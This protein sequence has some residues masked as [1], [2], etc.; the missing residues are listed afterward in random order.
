MTE[1][2]QYQPDDY[3]E[4]RG[5]TAY[6]AYTESAPYAQYKQAQEAF[7]RDL[8]ADVRPRRMLDFGCGSGKSFPLWADIPEV[9]GYDRARS[10]IDVARIE[11][12]RLR[13]HQPYRLMHCLTGDRT[14][15]PYDDDYFDLVTV[16]EV[17]L[18]VLPGEIGALVCELHRICRGRLVIVTAAPFDSPAPH[19]F[20][21]D[22]ASLL[23]DRFE[24]V[25]DHVVL[26][27]RY[28]VARKLPVRS[29]RT[30]DAEL[31][32]AHTN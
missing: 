23:S 27:Q 24:I 30:R 21:H 13:P 22:Y 16:I 26:Q 7:F 29:G 18:H 25:D 3:W 31:Q 10:Q 17:L 2:P 8:L 5:G 32:L 14:E 9:H 15:T 28:I 1:L 12:I 19:N 4:D 11:S 6:K 20:N